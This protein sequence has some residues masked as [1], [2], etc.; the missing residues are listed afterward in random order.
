MKY[1]WFYGKS[2]VLPFFFHFA[3]GS[4]EHSDVQPLENRE[5]Y[6]QNVKEQSAQ[7]P[8]PH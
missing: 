3:T 2:I 6:A 7:L 5:K 8:S 4:W 1:I